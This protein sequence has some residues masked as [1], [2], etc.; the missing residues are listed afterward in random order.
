MQLTVNGIS[1]LRAI[2]RMRR[3]QTLAAAPRCDLLPPSPAPAQRWT[4]KL[5][6]LDALGLEEAPSAERPLGIAVASPEQRVR[7]AFA[8]STTFTGTLPDGAF[9]KVGEGLAISSPELLFVE[10]A[11]V[12]PQAVHVLLGYELCG[13]FSRDEADPR[14]GEV[15]LGVAPA[16]S[17][18]KIRVFIDACS[19]VHGCALARKHLAYVS[20]NAWSPMEAVLATMASLS[21]AEQGYGLGR[22]VLNAR[23]DNAPE[24]VGLGVAASRVPDVVIEGAPVGF[25]YDGRWHLGLCDLRDAEDESGFER[26]ERA[27][28]EKYVD[29][30]R[31]NRE[32]AAAGLTILPVTSE[33]LFA[34]GGLDAVMLEAALAMRARGREP[35]DDVWAAIRSKKVSAARQNLIWSLLPWKEAPRLARERQEWLRGERAHV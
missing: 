13:G 1:A 2:R 17:A 6:P 23:C 32:L 27:V 35:R 16:T 34:E 20:D 26:A 3:E 14:M 15:A 25:N 28:R 9:L 8:E 19:G 12:M 4:K 11:S 24:L 5:V 21:V 33:D 7:A 22:A 10:M 29:D 18:E 30:L 31:R